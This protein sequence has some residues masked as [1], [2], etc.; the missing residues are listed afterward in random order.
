MI[1]LYWWLKSSDKLVKLQTACFLFPLCPTPQ[2]EFLIQ[3]I[4]SLRICISHMF[5]ADTDIADLG[6]P[7]FQNPG[8]YQFIF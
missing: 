1:H 6:E 3:E 8:P 2:P 5:L 4:Q 7:H